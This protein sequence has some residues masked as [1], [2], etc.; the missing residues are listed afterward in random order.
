ME[1][2]ILGVPHFIKRQKFFLLSLKELFSHFLSQVR[3]STL[4]D[5]LIFEGEQL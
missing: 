2:Y 1:I 5:W 3:H 4:I